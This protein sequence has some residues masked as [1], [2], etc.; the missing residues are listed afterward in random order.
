MLQPSRRNTSQVYHLRWLKLDF[1][2]G[3]VAGVRFRPEQSP[4]VRRSARLLEET[5]L[6]GRECA[7]GTGCHRPGSN[8]GTPS[9]DKKEKR[10]EKHA[11]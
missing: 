9:K 4:T 1:A 11:P 8:P 7:T 3:L 2:Q 10:W 5:R 6:S